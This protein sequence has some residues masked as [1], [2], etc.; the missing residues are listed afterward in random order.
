VDKSKVSD[1]L[2]DLG[3]R[4]ESKSKIHFAGLKSTPSGKCKGLEKN[5]W[6]I[7]ITY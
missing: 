6:K 3:K 4:V 7:M 1:G 2:I 5:S